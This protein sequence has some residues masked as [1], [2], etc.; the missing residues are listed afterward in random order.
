MSREYSRLK[1]T[2]PAS[3]SRKK[4]EEG[5]GK[6]SPGKQSALY[7]SLAHDLEATKDRYRVESTHVPVW[8]TVGLT[9]SRE[10]MCADIRKLTCDRK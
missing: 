7:Q 3:S 6:R 5:D 4:Q 2:R 1:L 10:L 8:H 9:I